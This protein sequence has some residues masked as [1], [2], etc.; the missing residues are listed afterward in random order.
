MKA[1]IGYKIQDG[2]WGGGNNFVNS[3]TT[4]LLE[5]GNEVIN[6][7]N[8]DDID[9]ILI[10]DPR[11]SNPAVTFSSKD[12][13]KYLS[14][15]NHRA[16]VVHRIN[17][18][19]ERKKTNFMNFRLKLINYL[20]DHTVFIASWL[21]SLNLW[22]PHLSDSTIILNGADTNI[23]NINNKK[24]WNGSE[25]LSLVTHHW[26]GNKMKGFD[27]YSMIDDMLNTGEWNEK[28]SFTYIGNLPKGFKFKNSSHYSP[29]QGKE[30]ANELRKHHV[31]ITASLN[32]PAG[33]H[34]IEGASCGLPLLY[35]NSGALPEYCNG[36]GLQFDLNNFTYILKKM[37]NEYHIYYKNIKN[38]PYS[39]NKMC[40][41]YYELFNKLI[42]KKEFYIKRRSSLKRPFIS[43]LNNLS[44]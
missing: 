22:N 35:R 30:L 43:I 10:I 19:D 37:M 28:I 31:Y 17:E 29:M 14:K 41:E 16:I 4:Y 11:K 20:T 27:V 21:K 26:A 18:C 13:M 15:K 38:Y 3:L 6:H 42:D 8:D 44:L 40:R 36:Y 7:L 1:S 25:K 23:F 33:M 34:H 2:P 24:T 32:E 9:I 12:I 5:N 39:S